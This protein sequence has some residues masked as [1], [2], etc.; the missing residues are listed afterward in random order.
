MAKKCYFILS[1]KY[2]DDK[3]MMELQNKAA[4]YYGLKDY[5]DSLSGSTLN[6]L[7]KLI[8]DNYFKE[9]NEYNASLLFIGLSSI[10]IA[11]S[12]SIYVAKDWADDDYCKICH[13]LAF[14]HG[15]DIVYESV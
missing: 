11:K 13:S 7:M 1:P 12:D 8:S 2:D 4:S 5:E 14:S 6:G 15:V 9:S 3:R 10:M